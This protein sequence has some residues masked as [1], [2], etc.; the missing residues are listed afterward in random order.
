MNQK[1]TT[2]NRQAN[3]RLGH[4]SPIGPRHTLPPDHRATSTPPPHGA[5]EQSGNH[6]AM[7]LPNQSNHSRLPFGMVHCR[8]NKLE[9]SRGD[10]R[11]GHTLPPTGRPDRCSAFVTEVNT[12]SVTEN[13]S[14]Q[15]DTATRTYRRAEPLSVQVRAVGLWSETL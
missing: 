5:T 4:G 13:A 8:C 1:H 3:V 2:H 7:F 6:Q 15:R 12:C 10:L 11:K 14:L 9:R